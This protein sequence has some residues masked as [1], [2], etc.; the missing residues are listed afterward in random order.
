MYR[1]SETQTNPYTPE[2]VV[3]PGSAPEVLRLATLSLRCVASHLFGSCVRSP[4]NLT[5]SVVLDFC[6]ASGHLTRPAVTTACVPFPVYCLALQR[7]NACWRVLH[8]I[9]FSARLCL[10][11]NTTTIPG[12]G[13][14]AGLNEVIMIERARSKREW[15]KT[16]PTIVDESSKEER[17][18]MMEEQD[19]MEWK[20]RE[21]EIEEIQK[22]RLQKLEQYFVE[23]DDENINKVNAKLESVLAKQEQRKATRDFKRQREGL[24][25][26]RRLVQKRA[27]PEKKL[28]RRNIIDDLLRSRLG[29]VCEDG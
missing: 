8:P 1:E 29:S 18:R 16:L 20:W 5:R 26:L 25:V 27:N 14:P 15:E 9:S 13:L 22:A 24:K 7:A 28:M 3:R 21:E 17:V 19:A 11:V 12:Q 23:R 6:N 10:F 2:Y 4:R